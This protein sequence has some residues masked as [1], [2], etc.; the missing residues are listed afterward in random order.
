ML[1]QVEAVNGYSGVKSITSSTSIG[2]IFSSFRTFAALYADA[3]CAIVMTGGFAAVAPLPVLKLGRCDCL[4][5]N[6][7]SFAKYSLL[8][9]ALLLLPVMP[10]VHG[11]A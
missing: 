2:A 9:R 7:G 4:P 3:R 10:P 6:S 1:L 11:K 5:V 8:S